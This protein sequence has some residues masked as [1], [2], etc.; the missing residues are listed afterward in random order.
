MNIWATQVLV[1]M[2]VLGWTAQVVSQGKRDNAIDTEY[3]AQLANAK[4]NDVDRATLPRKLLW[5]GISLINPD[6]RY[7]LVPLFG[8]SISNLD[9]KWSEEHLGNVL[10]KVEAG[11]VRLA[12]L[13]L[14]AVA[15]DSGNTYKGQGIQVSSKKNSNFPVYTQAQVSNFLKANSIDISYKDMIAFSQPLSDVDFKEEFIANSTLWA[16]DSSVRLPDKDT[17]STSLVKK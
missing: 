14:D 6:E 12:I 9:E 4:P 8:Y 10:A 5:A 15:S 11:S 17:A 7:K 13:K 1:L 16:N 3:S 2:M